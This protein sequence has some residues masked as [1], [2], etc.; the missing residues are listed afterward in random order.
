M[1]VSVAR[2]ART[3]ERQ[4]RDHELNEHVVLDEPSRASALKDCNHLHQFLACQRK[5]EGW[6]ALKSRFFLL[7][8]K[9]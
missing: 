5:R 8:V 1:V 2:R 6:D 9:T 3:A 4:A 7:C